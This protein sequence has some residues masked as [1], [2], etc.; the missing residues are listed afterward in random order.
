MTFIIDKKATGKRIKNLSQ[1]KGI[2]QAQLAVELDRNKKTISNWFC[3]ET[4]PKTIDELKKLSWILETSIEEILVMVDHK[5]DCKWE[6]L[7]VIEDD[8]SKRKVIEERN[9][10]FD[11]QIKKAIAKIGVSIQTID[12]T[13]RIN[14]H[15]AEGY[16]W[17]EVHDIVALP[18][19]KKQAIYNFINAR[20]EYEYLSGEEF[21]T[22]EWYKID[23]GEILVSYLLKETE[24]LNK[25]NVA[26]KK[27]RS[28]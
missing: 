10:S 7:Y 14:Q 6:E 2:S 19:L 18:G 1:N 5:S 15:G 25:K 17:T 27:N 26:L 28:M 23:L 8:N 13:K 24:I 22:D 21:K 11:E 4:L 20:N 3:G 12:E 9:L 16:Y